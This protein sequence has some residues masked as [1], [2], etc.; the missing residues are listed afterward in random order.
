[1]NCSPPSLAAHAI[2]I[3]SAGLDC[4]DSA[5]LGWILTHK[6]QISAA[7]LEFALE[8]QRHGRKLLGELLLEHRLISAEQ[9][10]MAL[11]EQFWRRNGYWI[12]SC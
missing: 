8:E 2:S 9:L 6:N 11:K 7:Q 10:E 4:G 1:M 12:I 5:H 3:A